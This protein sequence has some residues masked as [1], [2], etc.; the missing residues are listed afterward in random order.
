VIAFFSLKSGTQVALQL[1]DS[2]EFCGLYLGRL[3]RDLVY[4]S[5]ISESLLNK[6][7]WMWWCTFESKT[8]ETEAGV[9][10]WFQCQPWLHSNFRV[11]KAVWDPVSK[12]LGKVS[13]EFLDILSFVWVYLFSSPF[14]STVKIS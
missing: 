14:F 12:T 9:Y 11:L 10:M 1:V 13:M 8:W 3:C 6:Y 2:L 7:S 5:F 4:G